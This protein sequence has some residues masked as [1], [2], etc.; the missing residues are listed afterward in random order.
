[1]NCGLDDFDGIICC[2]GQGSFLRLK[3]AITFMN[4]WVIFEKCD[5]KLI[6]DDALDMAMC[7]N[8]DGKIICTYR[9]GDDLIVKISNNMAIKSS[10]IDNSNFSDDI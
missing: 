7:L 6:M 3:V 5:F 4:T 8:Q 10:A 2:D 9:F 1:M